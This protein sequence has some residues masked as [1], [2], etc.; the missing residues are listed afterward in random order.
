MKFV[1]FLCVQGTGKT[2]TGVHIAWLYAKEIRKRRVKRSKLFVCAPSNEAVDLIASRFYTSLT[3]ISSTSLA[4]VG[5]LKGLIANRSRGKQ[6]NDDEDD[7]DDDDIT[8]LRVYSESI[9]QAAYS[10][11]WIFNRYKPAGMP[12]RDAHSKESDDLY[13]ISLH[14]MVRDVTQ[15]DEEKKEKARKIL[16]KENDFQERFE[17]N[18][19]DDVP[20]KRE[21]DDYFT[22]VRSAERPEVKRA[23]IILCT[24]IN[25][26]S[27]KFQDIE[28]SH[29]IVDEAG[30]CTEPE[31]LV[32]INGTTKRI[33]LIGDHK[34]LRPVVQNNDVTEVLS[35]SM[36]ERLFENERSG[37]GPRAKQSSR[38]VMLTTQYRMVSFI[39][40]SIDI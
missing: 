13:D 40:E 39:I 20:S 4:F 31:T 16:E 6:E 9:A 7:D 2:V 28:K 17:S 30:Q 27:K 18:D 21:V 38:A 32:A 26:A 36:F 24:C 15:A 22:V 5:K 23:D 12:D 29:C 35:I 1:C 19:E 3:I 34:Q 25:A 8:I 14:R 11:P 10:G 33:V 37:L